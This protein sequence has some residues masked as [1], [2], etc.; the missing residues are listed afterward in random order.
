M[1]KEF[2][3]N[4]DLKAF[5][6]LAPLIG[7]RSQWANKV[8]RDLREKEK[9]DPDHI[10][11]DSKFFTGYYGEMSD[12]VPDEHWEYL[13]TPEKLSGVELSLDHQIDFLMAHRAADKNYRPVV[14]VDFGGM[15][16][17]S[18]VKLAKKHEKEIAQSKLALAVSNL[19]Y[20]VD[21]EL[22]NYDIDAYKNDFR[23]FPYCFVKANR[24]LIHFIL[25][26]AAELRSRSLSLPDG[27]NLLLKGNIDILHEKHALEHGI[28]DDVDFPLLGKT[29]SENGVIL[30]GSGWDPYGD[31]IRGFG[32]PRDPNDPFQGS[33]NPFR[34]G[35]DNLRKLGL[36]EV[37]NDMLRRYRVFKKPGAKLSP[38]IM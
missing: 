22:K 32:A 27:T 18:F 15:L 29:L 30:L 20:D 3:T 9:S 4:P 12:N 6:N 37:P 17:Y 23:I 8:K 19:A 25:S 21:K 33:G 5:K 24:A 11:D 31:P 2:K 14:A 1:A 28:K 13:Y 35:L 7:D 16:G 38:K 36:E 26:D 10:H 34:L